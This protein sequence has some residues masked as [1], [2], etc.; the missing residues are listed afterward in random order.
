MPNFGLQR[1]WKQFLSYETFERVASRIVMLFISLIIVY[2]LVLMAITLFDQLKFSRYLYRYRIAARR[3]WFNSLDIDSDRV[4]SL[5]CVSDL[6]ES[7]HPTS[8]AHSVNNDIGHRAK[9]DLTRF[10][11]GNIRTADR[12]RRPCACIRA[13]VL[14]DQCTS[15]FTGIQIRRLVHYHSQK[16]PALSL[17]RSGTL[18][19]STPAEGV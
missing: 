9:S 10:F 19:A 18:I 12:H 7:R 2:T 17:H 14:A 6:E 11:H 3:L 13:F 8:P 5:D 16:V 4:Q 15:R 1:D